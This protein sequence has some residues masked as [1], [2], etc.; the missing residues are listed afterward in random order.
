[1]S[2]LPTRAPTPCRRHARRRRRRGSRCSAPCV[3]ATGGN[4]REVAW[5]PPRLREGRFGA[6]IVFGVVVWKSGVQC[7]GRYHV[8]RGVTGGG[9][10]PRTRA[11]RPAP[12][13]L[14]DGSGAVCV[15]RNPA[16]PRQ[17][18]TAHV[19]QPTNRTLT[20]I[21]IITRDESS[22]RITGHR[23]SNWQL[24]LYPPTPYP[25]VG[26]PRG[27]STQKKTMKASNPEKLKRVEKSARNGFSREISRNTAI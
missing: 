24:Q 11:Q 19:L 22:Y 6:P 18:K 12:L 13:G 27:P 26:A 2:P 9:M 14:C 25:S 16:R 10:V 20:S 23:N 17:Y 8:P 21:R 7:W 4:V 15:Q 1:M 5:R 3:H